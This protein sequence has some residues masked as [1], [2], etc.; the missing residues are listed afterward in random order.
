MIIIAAGRNPCRRP[1]PSLYRNLR[2]DPTKD[3]EPIGLVTKALQAALKDPAIVSRFEELG[4]SRCPR[5]RATPAALGAHLRTEIAKW[6][7]I[8]KKAG[9]YAG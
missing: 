3:L 4:T 8:I 5:A 7:P 6:A 2:F 1:A 9:L